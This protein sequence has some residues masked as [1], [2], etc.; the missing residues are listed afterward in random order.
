MTYQMPKR[1]QAKIDK[2]RADLT[3]AHAA[4]DPQK[5][6]DILANITDGTLQGWGFKLAEEV[7][8]RPEFYAGSIR[9]HLPVDKVVERPAPVVGGPCDLAFNLTGQLFTVGVREGYVT[10]LVLAH[11]V[12]DRYNVPVDIHGAP[13]GIHTVKPADRQY[14]VP[15]R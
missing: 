1:F 12:A 6:A 5:A 3:A 7:G 15:V 8:F 4:R 2:L 13:Q 14:V 11:A 10:A 9:V